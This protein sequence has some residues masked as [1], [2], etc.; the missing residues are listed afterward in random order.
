MT[1]TQ[2]KDT[3]IEANLF[4]GGLELVEWRASEGLQALIHTD[5]LL[6]WGL[7][8]LLILIQLRCYSCL[9]GCCGHILPLHAQMIVPR[10]HDISLSSNLIPCI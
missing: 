2:S 4:Y 7:M 5:Y 6:R 3:Y 1:H 10:K 8:L 9:G